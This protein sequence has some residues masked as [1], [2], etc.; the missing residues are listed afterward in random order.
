MHI[1]ISGNIGS[2]K[3]TL[4]SM[5]ARHYGWTARY[6]P[7]VQNPYLSDF[8]RSPGRWAFPLEVFFLKE[9][10]RDALETARCPGTVIQDRTIYEGVNVFTRNNHE[11]GTL[12]DLDFATYME[13][14]AE[15]LSKLRLPDLMLYLRSPLD[16]L[17]GNIQRRGRDYERGMQLD[18]L[19]DLNRLYDEFIYGS[20]AGRVLTIDVTELDFEH[21]P[22]DFRHI[23]SRLDPLVGGLFP[24]TDQQL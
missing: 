4:T 19:S 20:Y 22:E 24:L 17:V 11:R 7:V 3:T 5:L 2:G 21:R 16:R 15:M 1:A 23:T 8:Y 14:Y 6:E 13:L 9:R 18:Y 12:S 10:F